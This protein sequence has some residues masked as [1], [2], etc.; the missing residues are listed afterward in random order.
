[1]LRLI[2]RG[3]NHFCHAQFHQL[4]SIIVGFGDCI[5]ISSAHHLLPVDELPLVRRLR[6]RACLGN[7]QG[8]CVCGY[9]RVCALCR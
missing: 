4:Q 9:M 5:D 6:C 3:V 1:M 7:L 2:V 8:M